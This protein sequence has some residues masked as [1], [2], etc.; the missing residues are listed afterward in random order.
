MS[1]HL[2]RAIRRL[3]EAFEEGAQAF[4]RDLGREVEEIFSGGFDCVRVAH[5]AYELTFSDLREIQEGIE[6]D[7]RATDMPGQENPYQVPP[8]AVRLRLRDAGARLKVRRWLPPLIWAG[9]ILVITSLPGTAIPTV[10]SP[11]DKAVH[12]TVYGL[13]GVLLARELSHVTTRWR[14]VLLAIGIAL[15]FGAADEWHQQFIPGRSSDVADWR[16]D[17]IG[18]IGGAL[19][20]SV[21]VLSRRNRFSHTNE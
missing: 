18:A 4:F 16:W 12:C 3:P 14:A 10:L 1:H 13:F 6:L 15:A 19:I 2:P 7:P 8:P 9:V 20:W 21:W 17:S 11:F 5:F